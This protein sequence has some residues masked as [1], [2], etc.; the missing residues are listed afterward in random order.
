[1][2]V[3]VYKTEPYLCRCV[4]SLLIQTFKDFDLVLIDDGSPDGCGKICDEY[5]RQDYRVHVIHQENGGLSAA[6]NAGLDWASANSGSRWI[7]FVDSD[8]WVHPYY[9]E[10]LKRA[11]VQGN[12]RVAICG[13]LWTAGEPLSEPDEDAV[14]IYK[15]KDY[16]YKETVNASVAWGKLY[17]KACFQDIRF[18]VGRIHEDEF[19]TYK[20]LFQ[21]ERL[22]VI[23]AQLYAYFQNDSGIMRGK[24]TVKRLDALEAIEEQI[25]FFDKE[26]YPDIAR[27]RFVS[28]VNNWKK[29]R[30]LLR[31]CNTMSER[32]KQ[33]TRKLMDRQLRRVIRRYRRYHWLP[34]KNR[35]NEQLYNEVFP[36]FQAMRRLW[37]R[38]K[39]LLKAMP[40]ARFLG[41]RVMRVVRRRKDIVRLAKYIC[42]S[43][44]KEAVLLHSPTYGNLGDQAIA[45]AELEL[46]KRAGVSCADFPWSQGIEDW[47]TRF[48]P[49][50]RLILLQG[51]GNLGQLWPRE[52]NRFRASIRAFRD[53]P[54]IFFP[55]TVYFDLN[56]E[57]GRCCFEESRAVYSTHPNLTIFLREKYSY[58]FMRQH[59]PEI[60]V[61]LV[62]DIVM[63]LATSIVQKAREDVLICL[64]GDKEQTLDEA[65]RQRLIEMLNACGQTIR[66]TD[67]LV[68]GNVAPEK[69]AGLVNEKL[70]EFAASRV[71]ITDRLHGMIFAAITQT[72][73]IVL[74]SLSHKLRG[75]YEWLKDLDYILFADSVD[76]IPAMM[77][78]LMSVHPEYSRTEIERSMGPL[79]EAI[80]NA[81]K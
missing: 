48:T 63:S 68:P 18:P 44:G 72:P 31:Q 29:N 23:S 6:R 64:R 11:A 28:L 80:R 74:D 10:W 15:P 52:E 40:P 71:V 46:L 75:C 21:Q 69:R 13:A 30:E 59:M 47:C 3:P 38:M 58:D 65:D 26:G 61:E 53:N 9:L 24:W 22:S 33:Q 19:V 5:A 57:E 67:M 43:L 12:T 50:K 37:G 20:I 27:K 55:Q 60:H 56:T 41:S 51:G 66:L 14:A 17:N 54:I 62:P 25:A 8:D 79:R 78:K 32:E 7:S 81:A 76:E 39:R 1:M 49:R 73:C 34:Y 70:A 16:Y 36:L 45:L 2:I 4:D 35:K 77:E 42:A